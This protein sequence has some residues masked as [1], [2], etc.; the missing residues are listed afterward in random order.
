MPEN[1]QDGVQTPVPMTKEMMESIIKYKNIQPSYAEDGTTITK[2]QGTV[3]VD[4]YTGSDIFSTLLSLDSKNLNYQTVGTGN[5][6]V[7]QFPHGGTQLE[8][9][10]QITL[11]V[12]KGEDDEGTMPVPDV[13]GKTYTEAV[14]LLNDSGFEAE[15]ENEKTKG[16][17]LSQKPKYGV[18]VELG[19][20]ITL[21]MGEK[22]DEED[23]TTNE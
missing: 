2:K 23:N 5:V 9:G 4:D 11:Y 10:S 22:E 6:V 1:N 8:E 20:K 12:E 13:R 15:A 18:S 19:T 7:N 3:T 17:V 21:T 16:V 14:T